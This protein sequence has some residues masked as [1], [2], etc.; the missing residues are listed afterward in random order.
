MHPIL[1]KTG[2]INI[3]SYGVM[4]ATAF[5]MAVF[6]ARR[7]AK[8]AHISPDIITDLGLVL[9]FSGIAGARLLYVILNIQDYI[10]N[11]FEILLLSHGGL[12]F[13]GGAVAASIAGIVYV[14]LKGLSVYKL[15]DL[16]APYAALG[17]AIGRIG[18]FLNG[19][20]FGKSGHPVQIYSSLTLIFIYGLLRL[21]QRLKV[22]PGLVLVS[23][24]ALY[25]VKRFF[26][27]FLRDDNI[28]ILFGLTF[29]QF[30]SVIVFIVCISILFQRILARE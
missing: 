14:K 15:G 1:F 8:E 21:L 11:P 20:C 27:E 5:F 7:S 9:L 13:Y 2:E 10:R 18:C 25:G 24:G 26:M 23:Y 16:I 29:S 22:K 4:L 30:I 28:I 3:Y 19:C 12:A 17:Q 6:L